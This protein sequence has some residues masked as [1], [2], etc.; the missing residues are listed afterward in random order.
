M[1][2]S[3]F[4]ITVNDSVFS[5]KGAGLH[6]GI[7]FTGCFILQFVCYLILPHMGIRYSQ[8]VEEYLPVAM[9][10]ISMLIV[11]VFYYIRDKRTDGVMPVDIVVSGDGISITIGD[12]QYIRKMNEIV[13]ISKVMVINRMYNEKGKYKVK[14]KCHGKCDIILESTE[15]E[16]DRHLDFENTGLFIMYNEC[17]KMGIKCC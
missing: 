8:A 2:E 17:K 1:R 9:L 13:E 7:L 5:T 6:R 14:I 12:K 16:Y 10:V 3:K 4:R 11:C 15:Q